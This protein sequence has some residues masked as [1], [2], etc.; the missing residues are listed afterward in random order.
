M[1]SKTRSSSG[2]R[3]S[4]LDINI[5]SNASPALRRRVLGPLDNNLLLI[6]MIQTIKY[7]PILLLRLL[8]VEK[9]A[10]QTFK[11]IFH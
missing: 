2:K 10:Y 11:S 8:V 1:S 6:L 3:Q 9:I 5:E 7:H 4:S